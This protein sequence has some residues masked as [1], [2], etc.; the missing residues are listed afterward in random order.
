MKNKFAAIAILAILS[1]SLVASIATISSVAASSSSDEAEIITTPDNSNIF[2]VTGTNFDASDGITLELIANGTTY[3][4][5]TNDV[6]ISTN[7]NGTFTAIVII[8]TNVDGGNYNLTASTEDQSAY[9]EITIPDLT[10][11]TGATGATGSTGATGATGAKG[12]DGA[13]GQDADQALTYG[14]I[15]L[16]LLGLVVATYAVMRKPS[17]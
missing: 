14:T 10:G 16:G 1:L 17:N 15:G 4:T 8:P 2:N 13:D 9:V 7:I 5:I 3:Y 6:E 11:A 12:S